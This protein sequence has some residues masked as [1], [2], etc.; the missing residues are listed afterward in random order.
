M[1]QRILLCLEERHIIA[2]QQL[3]LDE[4]EKGALDL[5]TSVVWPKL[6]TTML[7]SQ[8][9]STHGGAGGSLSRQRCDDLPKA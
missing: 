1:E 9:R 5:L 7:R 6:E 3:V 8:K 4:E 2:I